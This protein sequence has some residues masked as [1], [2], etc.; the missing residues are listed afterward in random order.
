MLTDQPFH[1]RKYADAG[2]VRRQHEGDWTILVFPDGDELRLPRTWAT[3]IAARMNWMHQHGY[4]LGLT[5][6]RLIDGV[7]PRPRKRQPLRPYKSTPATPSPFTPSRRPLHQLVTPGRVAGDDAG[8]LALVSLEQLEQLTASA[9]PQPPRPERAE[10][11]PRLAPKEK[12]R[13]L[14]TQPAAS[15]LNPTHDIKTRRGRVG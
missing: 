13:E 9:L 14:L 8:R 2:P 7:P 15:V 10:D 3:I 4:E 1:V 6:R 11:G 5:D 12:G